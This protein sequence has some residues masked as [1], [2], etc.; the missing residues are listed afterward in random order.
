[1]GKFGLNFFKPTEKFNGNWSIL[2]SKSREWEK[3]YR[4]RWS[5]DKEVRTTHGVN[6]TGSCS[7][8]VFVKNGVITW[9]NQQTDYPSCGP[10]MPEYEP[11]GCPRGAS[12]SWYEYSPLRI[13][14]P[15]IRGKLWDLWTEALEENNGNR[16]AAWASIVENEDKAKQYKQAR[17]MGGHVRS[18]WKDV[19][20]IIA[21]Q[22]LY[23]IKK[24]GPDRIAGF[25]PIPAMSMISYAAGAR[26]INL[27]GGEM[28]SFYDWYADLPPASPQIWG[29]QTDVPE[30]SDW[31]NA[32]YIIMWGSNVPLTRTPDA[33][34][35]TEVR[36]KGTKVISVAPDYAENVKFADNWLAPNPGSDAAIAQAMTHVILQE[37]YVDQ[38]NERFINYAKQYTDMPF[39]IMLD[40]DE[41]GY[42]AGRFLRASDLGQTTEQG[43]WK[44]VIHDAISDSL[45]VPN[46]TM[47]QRWEEGKKWNLKL[48]TEDGSKIN[49]TLSMTEGEYELETIQFPYFDSDGDGIFERPIP[50]RQVTLA[51]GD[52]VRIA[53][54]FDLMASQYGVRR[55]NHEL[56]S[57]GYDDAESKYTPAWQ[58]AISG[59]KQSVVIQV[60][61]EFAQN[62]IDT[63]GR[64]M[65][66]MG[67]GIN[68]W[69]NS[70][71]I[72]RSILNLVMLCGCQGVNGGGWAHYVGQEK[73]RPI[74]GW[75]TVAFAKDWQGPPR[76]Q[77]GTSWFYF[78]TDQWKYEESN[79]DRL[80]S[81]LAK[82]EELKHQHPAD[83]N[84]LAA[85][86]GWLPSYPQ[87]NKNSLLFAE[88][89]K[90]E[91]IDSNEEILQRA[92]DEV[93]SKQT[94]FAIEDP[95][96]KKNHPKSLFIWRS[97]LISS[98]AKGQE[99]FMKHLL[100]TKSGLLAT[101]NEDDKPEE[102]KWREETTG[103]LDLV[104][105]LDFRMT[106]TP[107]YSDIVLP[108]A[109]WYEKHDLSS[110]DMHPYVHP[111]NPAIDPLWESRSDWDIYKTLAKA[112]SEMAKDYLPGTFK[113]VVTTPLSHDTK[114]EI[115][116]PYGVVKDWSKGEIEAVPGR[117]MPNFAIVERDYTKIYDKYVTLGPVLEKGKVGAHGVSFGVS[118][119]YE[120]LKSMLGTWSDRDDDS[121]RANRPRIDTARNVADA[122]LSISSATN[123]KLSQKSYEN[124]EEQTG[125]PLKDISSERAAEKI[126]FLNITSQ[127]REVIPTAVFPGSNKQGRRY[128][129]FTT[130]I[131]RLVPFRTLTGRQSYYV[132]HEVFQQFG[133]SLPVYKPTL[134]PMVFGNRD[135]KIKGGTDALVL[136]YLTPHGKWNIHSM[137]QDNKHMLTL[138]RGGPTVWIS[139]EDAEQHDIHDNDWLEVYNRNGVVTARAVISHRM[140]KGTMFM[141][142]AQDKHIQTPGSEITDTRGGSHNA[143]TRIHLK[144]TQLVGGYAQISY[145]FNYYGPIGNQRDLYV[146]VRKMKE[147]NWLED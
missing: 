89:A 40:E 135:K 111:F 88:E 1:M 44:P 120:E 33:H 58:E 109:T 99:Y 20:D 3:M 51:N 82:T 79:V 73:C 36:Y 102:I 77:N 96:L 37:H 139:N 18:N 38:P 106:A 105:S 31:Y 83:Y 69:F 43:E 16:V 47:G 12:F 142:H 126:S 97:N 143:P 23:T 60:A 48:E 46:G 90:D 4:E 132:D 91:G 39:I 19:T 80:K 7:W 110:T 118:E 112:F 140:P 68:H 129:P 75:S 108:A 133:E 65:I 63:E 138:F 130:N 15:Y 8:K 67:A 41:N 95:D 113:D 10:D 84:V 62:A 123:G 21:A 81:P 35:M 24:Y 78:A 50:T 144:P 103:K 145:H 34:F 147:V 6:C 100:G 45:V 28:L 42:K 93:K 92:I 64:S 125:M 17:G 128:S 122:I 61:K 57:K 86:L 53:T 71:T 59:V 136:R 26:F 52:K 25:T 74:E 94:Q 32:S 54:I 2:E 101:P 127:P 141:Y 30:S 124:L 98:S 104:V 9:E 85:R 70:D 66:I 76:L 5:H 49:P 55:F 121:V 29:E 114:Q 72:Y 137:Y 119:Q 87:F 27:L 134:P 107:L 117:T 13:K 11:R 116:T 131:E 115:S 146:A 22:L 14:Y 56:E